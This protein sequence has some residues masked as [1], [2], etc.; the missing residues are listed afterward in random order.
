LRFGQAE[1]FQAIQLWPNCSTLFTYKGSLCA[2]IYR[3]QTP[4]QYNLFFCKH[5]LKYFKHLSISKLATGN[6]DP[7]LY[8][9]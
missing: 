2:V 6:L 4:K 3:Q 8:A 5:C 9:N 7:N 1:K